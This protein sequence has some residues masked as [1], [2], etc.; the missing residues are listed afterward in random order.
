M[1]NKSEVKNHGK[2]GDARRKTGNRGSDSM[3]G[4]QGMYWERQSAENDVR[5][6]KSCLKTGCNRLKCWTLGAPA[7]NVGRWDLQRPTPEV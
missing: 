6:E 4:C 3:H 7:S 2:A 1:E 5:I